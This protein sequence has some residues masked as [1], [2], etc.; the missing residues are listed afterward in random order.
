MFEKQ[1][2]MKAPI[3]FTK[4]FTNRNHAPMFR[5]S[6]TLESCGTARLSVCGLG[7]GYYYI[8]GRKV[9]GDLFTAPQSDYTKTL[10]YNEYDV[11][12]LLQEGENCIAVWLGNGWYNEDFETGWRFDEAV[13]R[14]VPK[15]MLRLEVDG[16]CTVVSDDSWKCQPDSAIYFNGLRSGEYFDAR[17]YDPEWVD[18]DYDDSSWVQ[19]VKDDNPPAGVFRKCPCEPIRECRVYACKE[20]IPAGEGRFIFDFGQN[21]SGY[22]R[23]R[24]AGDC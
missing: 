11:T 6:F 13:W 17:L 12:G 20:V 1:Q 7:I 16:V 4:E 10:W 15:C 3:P 14:D 19:A 2:F 22:I 18:T 23:L 5:K 24:I 21:M 8:N 9:S